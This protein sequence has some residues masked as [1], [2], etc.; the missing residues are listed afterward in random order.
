MALAACVVGLAAFCW[1]LRPAFDLVADGQTWISSD[2]YR[3]RDGFSTL[4]LAAINPKDE[5]SREIRAGEQRLMPYSRA[6]QPG[7]AQRAS[8]LPHAIE[9]RMPVLI[10]APF[11][12]A[13]FGDLIENRCAGFFIAVQNCLTET[14]NYQ[15][16]NDPNFSGKEN[17]SWVSAP[18]R[19][20]CLNV[21]ASW[22]AETNANIAE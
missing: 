17:C 14:Y 7:A 15:I 22:N 3:V 20:S 9:C 2:C 8:T 13:R 11:G 21:K 10:R 1:H 5:A 6:W 4:L 12:Q 19:S 18:A 16:Y